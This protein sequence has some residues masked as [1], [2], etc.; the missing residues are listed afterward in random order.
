MFIYLDD[1][2]LLGNTIVFSG[3]RFANFIAGFRTVRYDGQYG[4][5]HLSTN[6]V[7]NH[8]GFQINLKEGFIG[9]PQEN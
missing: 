3:K 1:I 6:Q 5:V 4:K 8:L 2:L 9:V 7:V